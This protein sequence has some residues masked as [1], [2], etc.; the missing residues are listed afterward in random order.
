MITIVIVD[1][2]EYPEYL[3]SPWRAGHLLQHLRYLATCM[4]VVTGMLLSFSPPLP[5]LLIILHVMIKRVSSVYRSIIK[6]NQSINRPNPFPPTFILR[7][8]TNQF[9]VRNLVVDFE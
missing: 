4:F 3:E 6:S 2:V 5:S 7:E 1:F 8:S 9:V